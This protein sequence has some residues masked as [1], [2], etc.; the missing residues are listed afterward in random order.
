MQDGNNYH[1]GTLTISDGMEMYYHAHRL[2]EDIE[3]LE[4]KLTTSEQ[5]QYLKKL[6]ED[7]ISY[8]QVV[9]E[10]FREKEL[11]INIYQSGRENKHIRSHIQVKF[12]Y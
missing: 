1:N 5:F 8:I 6:K 9:E 4:K 2:L 12:N 10:T 3:A 7:F 11:L